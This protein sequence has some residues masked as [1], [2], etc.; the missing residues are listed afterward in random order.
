MAEGIIDKIMQT[1]KGMEKDEATL[2]TIAGGQK[3]DL[4]TDNTK[5]SRDFNT[6]MEQVFLS[7]NHRNTP[8][9]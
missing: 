9:I 2:T 4:F 6:I 7:D 8:Y 1:F 3:V 5:I